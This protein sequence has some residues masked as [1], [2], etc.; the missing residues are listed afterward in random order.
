VVSTHVCIVSI[1]YI[2]SQCFSTVELS[3]VKEGG[4]E[5][6]LELVLPLMFDLF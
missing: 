5:L 6:Y 4:Y 3:I 1:V 2:D